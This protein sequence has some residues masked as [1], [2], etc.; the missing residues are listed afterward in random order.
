MH[1]NKHHENGGSRSTRA[2]AKR[3]GRVFLPICLLAVLAVVSIGGT[4]AYLTSS[5]A[6]VVNTFTVGDVDITLTE[7]KYNCKDENG[8]D[9]Y[10][11]APAEGVDNSYPM[12][13]GKTY[14]KDPTVTVVTPTTNIPVY[15]FVKF[16]ELGNAST[17]LEYTSL[18][19]ESKD[20]TPGDGT[21][22]PANVWYRTVDPTVTPLSWELLAKDANGYTITVNS[23]TVT[24]ETMA[25]ASNAKLKYTAY[26]IQTETFA[27]A[28]DAWKEVSK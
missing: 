25:A 1:M 12:V 20:W 16:E 7:T 13:P 24:E 21:K 18:L 19:S 3:I 4:V 23:N 14:K 17:Y 6:P 11:D 5:P 26:A 22:I 8:N 2:A 9:S 10:A 15:L 28:A 27:D